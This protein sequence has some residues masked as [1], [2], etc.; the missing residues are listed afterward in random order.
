MDFNITKMSTESFCNCPKLDPS[1]PLHIT[2]LGCPHHLNEKVDPWHYTGS[3]KMHSESNHANFIELCKKKLPQQKLPIEIGWTGYVNAN[4]EIFKLSNS[5][6]LD[7]VGRMVIL[8]DGYLIFQR[9]TQGDILLKSSNGITYN[10]LYDNEIDQFTT[11]LTS[12]P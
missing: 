7:E 9:Y 2:N 5:W 1:S 8:M 11:T 3:R 6:C 4:E 12:L 10:S